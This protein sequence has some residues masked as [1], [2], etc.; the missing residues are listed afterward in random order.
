M[1]CF[2]PVLPGDLLIG[3][4]YT[5]DLLTGDQFRDFTICSCSH[6]AV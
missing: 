1:R 4:Q 5:G 6:E 2:F 3:D